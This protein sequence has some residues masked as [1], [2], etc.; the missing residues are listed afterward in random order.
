MK[1]VTLIDEAHG[2]WVIDP[3]D[4][5]RFYVPNNG[6]TLYHKEYLEAMALIATNLRPE[7][8]SLLVRLLDGFFNNAGRFGI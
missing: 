7:K 6:T 4:K 2:H 3:V 1:P 8:E 5:W